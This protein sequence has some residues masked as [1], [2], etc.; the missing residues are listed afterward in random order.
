MAYAKKTSYSSSRPSQG[1]EVSNSS[2]GAVGEKDPATQTT[3]YAKRNKEYVNNVFIWENENEF[4]TY[5]KVRVTEVLQP[6]DYFIAR[7]KGA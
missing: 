2:S 4:G 1:G 5:L 7:K 6:G 3:H